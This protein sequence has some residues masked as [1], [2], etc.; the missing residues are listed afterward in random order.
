MRT[1]GK[2]EFKAMFQFS[3]VTQYLS[4]AKPM[5]VP[6][7]SV[8]ARRETEVEVDN[9]SAALRLIFKEASLAI[10]HFR[11][12]TFFPI[13]IRMKVMQLFLEFIKNKK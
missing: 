6:L 8:L 3:K 2:V 12:A 7:A 11:L 1:L 9:G 4:E 10:H 5:S 13:N